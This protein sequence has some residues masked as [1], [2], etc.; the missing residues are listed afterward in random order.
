[1]GRRNEARNGG[2]EQTWRRK[3]KWG[4]LAGTQRLGEAIVKRVAPTEAWHG[5]AWAGPGVALRKHWRQHN[6]LLP[7]RHTDPPMSQ[8][9]NATGS[10]GPSSL[11]DFKI[12][13]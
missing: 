8:A 12:S 9:R 5:A 2:N 7:H 1:V 4:G 3:S 11:Q 6:R 10:R 13:L